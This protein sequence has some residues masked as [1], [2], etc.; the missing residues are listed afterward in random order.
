M[1]FRN[2]HPQNI[3]FAMPTLTPLEI[4]NQANLFFKEGYYMTAITW[5]GLAIERPDIEHKLKIAILSNV[6]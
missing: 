4:K 3:V 6:S 5:Y 1:A 2:D